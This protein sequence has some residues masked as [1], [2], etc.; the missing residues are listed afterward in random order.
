MEIIF[1]LQSRCRTMQKIREAEEQVMIL[2]T[3]ST[4][5]RIRFEVVES[6]PE[7]QDGPDYYWNSCYKAIAAA[8]QALEIIEASPNKD[9]LTA[10]KARSTC[11]PCLCAFYA[12]Y[13]ICKSI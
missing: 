13:F 6:T 1:Y 5:N 3:G 4:G 12:C 2:L 10:H 9:Q 8:N 11:C 7:E